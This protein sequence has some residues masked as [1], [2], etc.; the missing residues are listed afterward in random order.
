MSYI[1]IDAGNSCL[2]IAIVNDLEDP[3]ISYHILDYTHLYDELRY[4]LQDCVLSKVLVSNVNNA[5]IFNII[6]DSVYDLWR[7]QAHL[8]YVEQDKYGI[9]TRYTNPRTLGCDRWLA[10]IA[11]RQEFNQS[12]CVIDCGTAVTIDVLSEN[13]MHLGGLISPGITTARHSLGLT[14]N[15]LP[16]VENTSENMNNKSSFFAINTQDAILGGTLYQISAYIERI[17]S[18]FK[19]EFGDNTECIITGG[20]AEL[21]L[22]LTRHLMHHR[23]ALVLDGLRIIAKEMFDRETS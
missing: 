19:L 8:V 18:E 17:V 11:A 9:S 22:S 23:D 14:T 5:T 21:I 20:D 4:Y 7:I 16:I 12:L 6:S 10:L 1:L 13:G 2:K 15:N 3:N